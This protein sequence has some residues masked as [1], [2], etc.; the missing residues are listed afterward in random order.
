MLQNH[1]HR[2]QVKKCA[3]ETRPGHCVLF[4]G[5]TFIFSILDVDLKMNIYF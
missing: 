2:L 5:K 1:I 3:F 4:L